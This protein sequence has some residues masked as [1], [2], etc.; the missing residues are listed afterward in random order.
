MAVLVAVFVGGLLRLVGV[1]FGECCQ[2]LGVLAVGDLV[3]QIAHLALETGDVLE[4]SVHVASSRHV[5]AVQR[6]PRHLLE[7]A[8]DLAAPTLTEG[9]ERGHVVALGEVVDGGAEPLVERIE[10]LL[11]QRRCRCCHD[12]SLWRHPTPAEP[13]GRRELF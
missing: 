7:T 4:Q 13:P 5:Q 1:P 10:E 9:G 11:P 6:A 3:A 12:A 2:E 8:V